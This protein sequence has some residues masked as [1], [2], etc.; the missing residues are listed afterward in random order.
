MNAPHTT[1]QAAPSIGDVAHETAD[2]LLMDAFESI[3]VIT[4]QYANNPT[5]AI[6]VL[7]HSLVAKLDSLEEAQRDLRKSIDFLAKTLIGQ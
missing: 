4:P 7:A 5:T 1:E 3:S 6:L 2:N